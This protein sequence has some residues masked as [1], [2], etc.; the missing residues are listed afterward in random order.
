MIEYSE[1]LTKGRRKQVSTEAKI[2]PFCKFA[3]LD[4]VRDFNG[5]KALPRCAKLMFLFIIITS[6]LFSNLNEQ[7]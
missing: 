5:K 1:F 2:Q 6:V 7:F 3:N 4:C